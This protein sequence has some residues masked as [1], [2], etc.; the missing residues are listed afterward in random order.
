MNIHKMIRSV[1]NACLMIIIGVCS[2]N[3]D[4]INFLNPG[5]ANDFHVT[6]AGPVT[7]VTVRAEN[8]AVSNGEVFPEIPGSD[9]AGLNFNWSWTTPLTTAEGGTIFLVYSPAP[10]AYT[11][12]FTYHT[13]GGPSQMVGQKITVVPEPSTFAVIA[14]LTVLSLVTLR[15]KNKIERQ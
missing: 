6:F 5:Q 9:P 4:I 12:W 1:L 14:G 8:Q 7:Q 10:I 15:R 3:A 13:A 2:A 11:Y